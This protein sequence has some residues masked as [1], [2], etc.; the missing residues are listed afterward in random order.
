MTARTAVETEIRMI[1]EDFYGEARID[2]ILSAG[3]V[4]A[5]D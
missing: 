5:R 4:A 3:C 2:R 1:V